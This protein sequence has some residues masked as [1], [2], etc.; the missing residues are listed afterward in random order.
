M[1]APSLT[2]GIEE[3]YQ[4]IDPKTR[5]LRSYITEILEEGRLILREQL[6]PELHQSIVEVGTK[7]CQTPAEIRSELVQLRRSIIELAEKNGLKIVAAGTHPFSSWL[8]QE[9]TPME[10]YMGVKQDMQELAQQL[11][12]FGTHVHIGIEDHEFLIDAMNVA[13][14]LMPHVL[15]LSTSSPFWMG[16]NTGLKS[17]RS[18]IFRN[19]PRSGIPRVFQSWADYTYLVDTLVQTHTIPD[20]S[21]IWWDARPNWSYPTLEFRIC[22]VCTRVDE[23]ACIAAIFQAI[24]AKLW[25]LRRDNM[26]FR[27]YPSDLIEENKW[28]AVRYGLDGKLIDFGKQEELPTRDL[29]R[30]MIEW[31]IGDVIDEL[32]SRKEVEYAYRILQEGTSADRQLATYQKTGDLNAVVD[33]LIRETSEF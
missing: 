22:D 31:F 24:I 8:A 19:F 29:I 2:L 20:G 21:K 9:I 1:K 17:Y 23:A 12:I 15:C 3:E 26:T 30:E 27:V 4:I 11:L 13:R 33:Q 32:G 16:R 14:Y 7:V 10:R 5:E 6:K 25:K 28:R 18:I